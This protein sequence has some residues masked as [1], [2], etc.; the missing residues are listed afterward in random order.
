[1]T[2]LYAA[3]EIKSD[4]RSTWRHLRDVGGEGDNARHRLLGVTSDCSKWSAGGPCG[5]SWNSDG[6]EGQWYVG[7]WAD[8][9]CDGVELGLVLQDTAVS[10]FDLLLV[11]EDVRFV[12][13]AKVP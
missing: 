9:R 7:H 10:L 3:V 1:M 13:I 4:C 11:A 8:L 5:R 6:I 12:G 2:H